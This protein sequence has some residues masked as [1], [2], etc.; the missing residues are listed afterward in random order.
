[1]TRWKKENLDQLRA[2]IETVDSPDEHVQ[3]LKHEVLKLLRAPAGRPGKWGES[4]QAKLLDALGE[5][6]TKPKFGGKKPNLGEAI[7][8]LIDKGGPYQGETVKSMRERIREAEKDPFVTSQRPIARGYLSRQ[9]SREDALQFGAAAAKQNPPRQDADA[10][11]VLKI[12]A[13]VTRLFEAL[14][15]AAAR[16]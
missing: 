14:Y 12:L 8:R 6:M 2:V 5:A 15:K 10:A 13:A 9:L 7:S 4:A 3:A 16:E 11:H 1:M